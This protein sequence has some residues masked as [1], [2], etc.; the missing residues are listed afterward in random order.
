VID[1]FTREAIAIE[2]DRGIDADGVVDVLDRLS[3]AHG[4]PHYVRF[5]RA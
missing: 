2:V 1:E 4:A 5:E 3:L